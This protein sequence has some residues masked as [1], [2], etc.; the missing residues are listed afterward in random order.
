[1][2]IRI[3]RTFDRRTFRRAITHAL[4]L[5]QRLE[6]H[7]EENPGY[8][9]A[10]T[11]GTIGI[12]LA[13][14]LMISA[15]IDWYNGPADDPAPTVAKSELGDDLGDADSDVMRGLRTDN[16]DD[17]D[18]ISYRFANRRDEN[19]DS[20]PADD[21][22][23]KPR[24][25]DRSSEPDIAEE[26]PDEPVADEPVE[27]RRSG[28][29]T[30]VETP[31]KRRIVIEEDEDDATT[32]EPP[33]PRIN[34]GV[35][36]F[37]IADKTEEQEFAKEMAADEDDDRRETVATT[38]TTEPAFLKTNGEREDAGDDEI[39]RREP[40]PA[41]RIEPDP[42]AD[43]QRA[44]TEQPSKRDEPGWQ[45]QRTRNE[46]PP[47]SAR[48]SRSAETIVVAPREVPPARRT[49]AAP[50]PRD[51]RPPKQ[52]A[53][54]TPFKLSISGPARVG[55]GEP[56]SYELSLT[57][58]GTTTARNLVVSIELPQGLAHEVAQSLEQDVLSIP[59][60]GTHRSLLRLKATHPGENV[61]H[62]DIVDGRRVAVQLTARVQ[63]GPTPAARRV[64]KSECCDEVVR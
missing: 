7:W 22:F 63:V 62:V 8:V 51:V 27:F 13:L 55:L 53:A 54:D 60:G 40:R 28:R 38:P 42:R 39:I 47:V 32:P 31:P 5:W 18:G 50:A 59:P 15:G 64:V 36:D 3:R 2:P 6:E 29:I 49:V 45:Q 19:D 25:F 1:M 23:L 14:A 56:C 44:R 4:L 48:K 35:D 21:P 33:A 20:D 12:L 16:D 9:A 26:S 61:I 57:N 41:R 46:A 52:P 10:A 17:D 24:K 34:L 43:V 11:A 37:K 30:V 58:T